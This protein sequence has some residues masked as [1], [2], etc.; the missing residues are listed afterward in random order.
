MVCNL[1][2]E[3]ATSSARAWSKLTGHFN[4]PR[5]PTMN[6]LLSQVQTPSRSARTHCNPIIENVSS[7][8]RID[9]LEPF[10]AGCPTHDAIPTS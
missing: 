5:K 2:N 3:L 4:T 10:T 9:S 6:H 8:M 7:A 1:L